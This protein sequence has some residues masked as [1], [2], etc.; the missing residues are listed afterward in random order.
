MSRE[1]EIQKLFKEIEKIKT[2]GHR[3]V[4]PVE[5][6][7]RVLVLMDEGYTRDFLCE[8]LNL[9]KAQIFSWKAQRDRG[10]NLMAP[11]KLK[12]IPI[13]SEPSK[14]DE[15]TLKEKEK[16]PPKLFFRFLSLKISWGS[17]YVPSNKT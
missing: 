7:N 2:S 17:G 11:Y 4:F 3:I 16:V 14:V 1:L 8:K 10:L 5:L 6:K 15:K 13:V 12:E 9:K